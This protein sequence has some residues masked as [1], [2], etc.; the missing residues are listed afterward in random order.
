MAGG[1]KGGSQ[2]TKVEIPAWLDAAGQ[3][4]LAKGEEIAKIGYTPFYGPDVAAL[5][6]DQE[7]AMRNT[8]SAA[9]AFGLGG[10]S[11]M[12]GMPEPQTFAGGVRGYS[13]GSL[14]DQAV[15]ELQNR[16]PGQ[17]EAL[18]AQFLDPYKTQPAAPEQPTE[19][20]PINPFQAHVPIRPGSY[21]W[22]RRLGK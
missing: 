3:R 16:R 4:A 11:P 1:G 15:S 7:A 6:P 20:G 10:T 21:E 14:Y 13:S 8:R 22:D 19:L 2:T 18:M 17:Y 12:G 9:S 5:T